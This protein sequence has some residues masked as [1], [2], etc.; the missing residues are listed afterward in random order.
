MSSWRERHPERHRETSRQWRIANAEKLSEQRRRRRK[1]RPDLS[2]IQCGTLFTPKAAHSQICSDECREA[3][4]KEYERNRPPRVIDHEKT[5]K[6]I[7]QWRKA[8]PEKV[9]EQK[10]RARAKD[11]EK[12]REQDRHQNAADP[13]K[14]SR[15]RKRNRLK[16]NERARRRYAADPERYRETRRVSYYNNIETEQAKARDRARWYAAHPEHLKAVRKRKK[17]SERQARYRVSSADKAQAVRQRYRA[18]NRE[19][20]RESERARRAAKKNT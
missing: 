20:A 3:R 9:R 16:I 4:S 1:P 15:Y 5:N 19:R 11:P 8:N 14:Y 18:K 17:T 10:R 6:R 7:R 13:G 2:C 12:T